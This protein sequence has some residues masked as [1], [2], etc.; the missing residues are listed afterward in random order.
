[1][2]NFWRFN[3]SGGEKQQQQQQFDY[4]EEDISELY[5]TTCFRLKISNLNPKFY[6]N[7]QGRPYK[8][9]PLIKSLLL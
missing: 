8:K 1:M 9:S 5:T 3:T 6:F 2:E 4:N 7:F